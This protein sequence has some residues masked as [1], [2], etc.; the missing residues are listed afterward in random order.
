[1]FVVV[2]VYVW[3]YVWEGRERMVLGCEGWCWVR[4]YGGLGG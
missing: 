2:V 4:D 1:M 3:G